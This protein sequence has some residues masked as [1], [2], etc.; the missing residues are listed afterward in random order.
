M[1]SIL[2]NCFDVKTEEDDTEI[3]KLIEE[4]GTFKKVLESYDW[5]RIVKPNATVIL[6]GGVKLVTDISVLKHLSVNSSITGP[7]TLRGV[8]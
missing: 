4:I 5:I 3:D 7:S 2:T 1:K 6:N 8:V